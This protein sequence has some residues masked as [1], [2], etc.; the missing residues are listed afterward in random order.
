MRGLL[1]LLMAGVLGGCADEFPTATHPPTLADPVTFEVRLPWSAFA[2]NLRVLGGFG[3]PADVFLSDNAVLND[4][5][6]NQKPDGLLAHQYAGELEARTLIRFP[7]LPRSA[8]VRDSLGTERTDTLLSFI[9][10]NVIVR[11]DTTNTAIPTGPVFLRLDRVAGPWDAGST[12][13]ELAVD[14]GAVRIPWP[15]PG[16]GPLVEYAT[17]AWDPTTGSES[18]MPL[19]SVETAFLRDTLQ[20]NRGL[21]MSL[22]SAGHR[23]DVEGIVLQLQVVPSV[24]PDSVLFVDIDPVQLTY[25]YTPSPDAPAANEVRVGGVPAW[26]SILTLGLPATVPGTPAVCART[27]CPIQLTA[28]RVNHAGLLLTTRPGDPVF[29]PIDTVE[30]EIRGVLAPEFLPKSPVASPLFVDSIGDPAGSP[31]PASAFRQGSTRVVELP[32]TP[33]LRD[34]LAGVEGGV[35]HPT[36]TITLLEVLEP[37]SFSLGTFAGPGQ[38]GEPVLR[39]VLTISNPVGLP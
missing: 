7:D 32:I 4:V 27:T 26:R 10:S 22:E 34:L 24:N 21:M 3:T 33:L 9:G 5:A 17:G 31:I 29:A 30:F 35:F 13:W 12:T 15:Q 28:D 19:D 37:L 14:S 39:L 23:L 25:I 18:I 36:P 38:P 20:A 6:L 2:S 16:G 8:T 1:T 11:F